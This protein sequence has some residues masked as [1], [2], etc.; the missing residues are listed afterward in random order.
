MTVLLILVISCFKMQIN[1]GDADDEAGY[2]VLALTVVAV[3]PVVPDEAPE[4]LISRYF[5]ALDTE[6]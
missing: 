2:A 4:A 3:E 6:Q 5:R 1:R